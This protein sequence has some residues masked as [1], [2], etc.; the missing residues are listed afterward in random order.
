M[1][2]GHRGPDWGPADRPHRP[3]Q[4]VRVRHPPGRDPAAGHHQLG[5]NSASSDPATGAPVGDPLTV[6]VTSCALGTRP[7]GTLL[8]ATTSPHGTVRLWGPGTG[9]A[10]GD[11]LTGHTHAVTGCAFG[12]RPD[13]T[14]PLATPS[15][16]DTVRLWDPAPSPHRGPADRPHSRGDRM[17]FRH[18]PRRHLAAGHHQ[19]GRHRATAGPGHRRPDRGRADRAIGILRRCAFGTR[20]DGTLL[21]AIKSLRGTVRLLDPGTGLPV[22]T[23]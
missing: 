10:I 19:L 22:G 9:A 23:R 3:S 6:A 11:P 12:T 18:P 1:G 20:P 8:L 16:D 2:C 4:R 21:L 15:Q 13:G 17:R 7:D 14:L 5:R